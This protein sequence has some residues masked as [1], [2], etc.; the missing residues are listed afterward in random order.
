MRR[1]GI[2][3]AM[4][5]LRRNSFS[6]IFCL[7]SLFIITAD[8]F[9]EK[10]IKNSKQNNSFRSNSASFNIA[11]FKE[12]DFPFQGVPFF[13]SPE[14]IFQNLSINF[15]VKYLDYSQISNENY[16]NSG[17]FDLLILPYGETFPYQAFP[18]IKRYIFEGG[19]IFSVAGRPFW[20]PVVKTDGQWQKVNTKD[21][22]RDFMA[23]L[24]IK[25]YESQENEDIGLTVTTSA[26]DNPVQPTH[27]NVFPYRIPVRD[28]YFFE[29][30]QNVQDAKQIVIIKSW[31]NPYMSASKN[32]PRKWCL[33]GAKGVGN[34][35]NPKNP[36]SQNRL[37]Q[38]IDN[39]TF[40]III[41]GLESN[42]AAYKQKEKVTVSLKAKNI[43]KNQ[44][45]A[46]LEF[47]FFGKNGTMA[48]RKKRNIRLGAGQETLLKEIWNPGE[49]KDSFYTVKAYLRKKDVVFD[50]EANGFVVINENN[51]KS[52]P[53]ITVEGNHFL[54]NKK[55]SIILGMNYYESKLGELM[56]LTPNLLRIREDFKS[57]RGLGINLV[58]IHYHH[59]KWFRD[60]F[61]NVVKKDLD[62]YL[63]SADYSA[64]P[65]ERS[66]RILDA[67]IQLAAE[68]NLIFCLDIF[69]LV[70]QEM[71]NPI[72]WLGLKERII[73]K[74]KI[75]VQKKFVALL[76]QRY[77]E[78]PGITW[79]LWNEPRLSVEDM[80]QL[81]SWAKELMNT[82]RK[83]GDSH[84]V[85]IGDDMSLC[86]LNELDYAC[87][88][89][90]NPANASKLSN[91]IKPFIFQEIWNAAGC[92]LKE[93]IEQADKLKKDFRNFMNTEAAGF[94]PWQWTRQARLWNSATDPEKWDDELGLCVRDDGSLKPAGT[95]FAELM[96]SIKKE[97]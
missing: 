59:S 25:Y 64:L 83:N 66:L 51:L 67:V 41:Y 72:G 73:D 16:F 69:S 23:E 62:P 32:S 84:L 12:K 43:G 42:Y 46:E 27:G 8:G 22:Y 15:P 78:V 31:K 21:A 65:S 13:L 7:V 93:E 86:L 92:S 17:N 50:K 29:D 47:V 94:V 56:W 9:A 52:G 87:I 30:L 74:E 48:F 88:H 35:L 40:P 44:E 37:T 55:K 91:L 96:D 58:R 4:T 97:N 95:V 81:R 11:I 3:K 63:N 71:G 24:G 14:W 68:E 80:E 34:P 82:F 49:F 70:P 39:L 77:R 19:G 2:D 18:Q 76:S 75:D 57:M 28:F 54:I 45:T 85:T 60:Y 90:Y 5:K 36:T 89:T 26:A 61:R 33:V 53:S 6:Y 10:N 38:I 79:D 1:A 20:I